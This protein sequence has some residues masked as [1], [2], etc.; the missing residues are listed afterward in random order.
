MSF[1]YDDTP[2]DFILK[3]SQCMAEKAWLFERIRKILAVSI[4]YD[5]KFKLD[6]EEEVMI[7]AYCM[8]GTKMMLYRVDGEH[9]G[10]TMNKKRRNTVL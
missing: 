3:A 1:N 4:Q 10:I 2:V 7:V 9:Y 6:N 8:G 5:C